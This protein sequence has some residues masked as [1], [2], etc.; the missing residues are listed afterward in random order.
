M[1]KL[2]VTMLSILACGAA[3]AL[4]VGNP[5]DASLLTDGLF[6]EGLCQDLC[7]PCF[8]WWD[9]WSFRVGFYGDYVFNRHLEVDSSDEVVD[10]GVIRKTTINTN[11]GY[12]ALNFFD[13]LDVFATLGA[14]N[15]GLQ[16]NELNFA[17]IPGFTDNGAF[18]LASS[19][20]FSWSIG[21]RATLWECGCTALG[22]EG[23]YFSTHPRVSRVSRDTLMSNYLDS[24]MKYH[25]WQVGLGISHRIQ[26]FVPYV[27]VKWSGSKADFNNEVFVVALSGGTDAFTGEL[28]NLKNARHWGYAVGVTFVDCEK[29]SIAVEGRFGDEKAVYVNGQIRF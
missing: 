16:S 27:A 17:L 21:G 22:L 8:S 18:E 29:A 19:T 11:A 2:F 9:A 15:F 28:V 7:D 23:Q 20:S 26:M 25:E 1:K 5:S 4:P 24:P 6:W 12:L 3:H 13:R 14:T 10:P